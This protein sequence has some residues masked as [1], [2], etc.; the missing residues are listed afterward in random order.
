MVLYRLISNTRL[1]CASARRGLFLMLL[2]GCL[3]LAANPLHARAVV[4]RIDGIVLKVRDGDTIQMLTA[5]G[6]R[7]EV[8]LNAIDAPEKAHGNVRGQ[9]HAE[10]ARLNLAQLAVRR[11][12]TLLRTTM[13][14]Y[15]RH[16]G[17]VLVRTAD[18]DIDAGW[19]QLRSGYAWVYERY[20]GEVPVATRI[21][22]RQAQT[23]ARSQRRGLWADPHPVAPWDWRKRQ[24]SP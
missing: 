11:N 13:D 24:R 4:D 22:Y 8:R 16:V 17:R 15:G 23:D 3:A 19:W 14:R 12:V 10:R 7:I 6:Q 5:A 18:A 9:P 21:E 20:L 2:L 1:P